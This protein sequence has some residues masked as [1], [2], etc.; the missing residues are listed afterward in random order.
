MGIW[1]KLRGKG[2]P[3]KE[4]ESPERPEAPA[5][6]AAAMRGPVGP[7]A[8][9]PGALAAAEQRS[10][11]PDLGIDPALLQHQ[12]GGPVPPPQEAVAS[13]DPEVDDQLARLARLSQL[14]ERG[15]LTPG[16]FEQQKRRILGS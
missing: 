7:G 6:V 10:K 3:A 13:A 12:E 14:R 9:P 5:P 4:D 2:G 15:E 8:M 16:E 11:L 1:G